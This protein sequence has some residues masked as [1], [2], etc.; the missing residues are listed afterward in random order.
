MKVSQY[1]NNLL[2]FCELGGSRVE[3]IFLRGFGARGPVSC[4][5]GKPPRM[6]MCS[7][8]FPACVW[9]VTQFGALKDLAARKLAGY[10]LHHHVMYTHGP[11]GTRTQEQTYLLSP[12]PDPTPPYDVSHSRVKSRGRVAAS[13]MSQKWGKSRSAAE[14][15]SKSVFLLSL[16][17]PQAPIRTF[18]CQVV[19]S[20]GR[21]S[22]SVGE[23]FGR[24]TRQMLLL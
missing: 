8:Y 3:V 15:T 12:F 16:V 17:S 14:L 2:R 10:M 7:I 5:A 18:S 24:V 23:R 4:C 13:Q 19:G 11:W 20:T 9:Q 6:L 1:F 22:S 21:F